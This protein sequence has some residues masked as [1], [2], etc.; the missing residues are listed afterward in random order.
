[1]MRRQKQRVVPERT[2]RGC[3]QWVDRASSALLEHVTAVTYERDS[4][5]DGTFTV[6]RMRAAEAL[7]LLKLA[8][9]D[10]DRAALLIII[11]TALDALSAA[12]RKDLSR[13]WM[14]RTMLCGARRSPS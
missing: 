12:D 8:K 6:V 1:M 11:A 2:K 4:R 7:E 14:K 5:R 13:P 9:P 10:S 3:R